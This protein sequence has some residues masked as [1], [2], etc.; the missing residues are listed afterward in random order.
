VIA[1]TA[2]PTRARSRWIAYG[3]CALAGLAML[4]WT[5]RR[6]PDV[7]VDFGGE[8]YVPWRL[9]E[10]DV[11]YRDVAYFTGPLSP[12]VNALWFRVFGT[13]FLTL[14]LANVAIIALIAALLLHVVEIVADGFAALVATIVFL[15]LFAFAQLEVYGNSNYVTPYSHET[16]HG[17][18]IALATIAVLARWMR[19]SSRTWLA[20]GGFL[21]GLAFLTK[22]EYFLAIACSSA[23]AIGAWFAC[24]G[25]RRRSIAVDALLYATSALVA[26]LVAFGALCTSASPSAALRGVLGAWPYVVDGRITSLRFYEFVM[27]TDRPALNARLLVQWLLPHVLLLGVPLAIALMSKR[28]RGSVASALACIVIAALVLGLQPSP[29]VWLEAFR[30]LPLFTA[31]ALGAS[32]AAVARA[33]GEAPTRAAESLDA[34]ARDAASGASASVRR[35][36]L[37]AGVCTFALVLLAK[38]VL[39]ARLQGYGYALA[40]P[41]MIVYC[42]AITSWIPRFVAA[43]GG[44]GGLFRAAALGLLVAAI[45]S[46]LAIMQSYFAA[47]TIEV[48]RGG[49][50]FLA[51]AR[52][53]IVNAALGHLEQRMRPD[54]TLAVLPEGVML[55]YLLRKKTPARYINYM[56][57]ELLMFDE[58]EIAADF[59]TRAPEW[60][61]IAHKSTSEYGLPF[62]GQ[63]YGARLF[64]WI[65]AH[66][67]VDA[68]FG[69]PPLEK[70]SRFGIRVL[71]RKH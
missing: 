14:A 36:A 6:W 2:A 4:A 8:L 40:M 24:R 68:T 30:P 59:A 56:P 39:N 9:R 37:Q 32:L 62:F 15:V 58:D 23:V 50:A 44:D 51:D 69:D 66:Y 67:D 17:T 13:S 3:A 45:V 26:P 64:A 65:G 41:A 28:K 31:F 16:T 53:S 61:A 38:M 12:Y 52:G 20:F 48:G 27:G 10:G 47:K 63:D 34:H 11:L 19:S 5:W 1:S 55:N 29:R 42:I 70:G 43:R 46:H 33:R 18:L 25:E 54:E 22:V 49:D 71:R 57:P 35:A 21:L 60:I 7:L